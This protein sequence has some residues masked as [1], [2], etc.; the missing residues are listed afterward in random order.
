MLIADFYTKPLQIKF[1]RLF[2]NLILNIEDSPTSNFQA[3]LTKLKQEPSLSHI[4]RTTLKACVEYNVCA[5][6]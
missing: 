4:K 2:R 5:N 3:A 6:K 1:F